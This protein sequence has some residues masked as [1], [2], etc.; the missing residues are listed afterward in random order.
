MFAK[1][2]GN[3]CKLLLQLSL[4][5]EKT[6][7]SLCLCLKLCTQM[8]P[9]VCIGSGA[10][11]NIGVMMIH[12]AGQKLLDLVLVPDAY[13]IGPTCIGESFI[14]QKFRKVTVSSASSMSLLGGT[15]WCGLGLRPKSLAR[16][17]Q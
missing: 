2:P 16:K 13:D 8:L 4:V 15:A 5:F 11:R 7:M 9:V 6:Y 17:I 1:P 12:G 14:E 3:T 10:L